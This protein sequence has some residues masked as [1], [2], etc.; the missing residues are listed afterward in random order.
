VLQRALNKQKR[1][2][3]KEILG[4]FFPSARARGQAQPLNTDP[5]VV[6]AQSLLVKSVTRE[7]AALQ[8][9]L[10]EY[11]RQIA[12]LFATHADHAAGA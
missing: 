8:A 11:E 12:V 10:M 9:I 1:A 5:A 6:A 3:I 2:V 4:E 7:L